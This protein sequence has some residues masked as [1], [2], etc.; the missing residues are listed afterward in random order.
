[1]FFFLILF[2]YNFFFIYIY[3][4]VSV[5]FLTNTP[6]QVSFLRFSSPVYSC[7]YCT[8]PKPYK[9]TAAGHS[10]GY[11]DIIIIM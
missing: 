5:S 2:R 6:A 9:S 10:I 8:A 1:M 11:H 4:A 7:T 3:F